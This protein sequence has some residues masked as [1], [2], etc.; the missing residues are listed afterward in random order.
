MKKRLKAIYTVEAS[1]TVPVF[2]VVILSVTM[3]FKMLSSLSYAES[4]SVFSAKSISDKLTLYLPYGICDAFYDASIKSDDGILPTQQQLDGF[5]NMLNVDYKL[6]KDKPETDDERY[7]S[8][9]SF[10]SYDELLY[11]DAYTEMKKLAD[12]FITENSDMDKN[13]CQEYFR[14]AYDKYLKEKS[15]L[16]KYNSLK[17]ECTK[18]TIEQ[19]D[20]ILVVN[21][22][23]RYDLKLPFGVVGKNSISSE[24]NITVPVYKR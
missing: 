18:A 16:S 8:N 9:F 14:Y 15:G 23:L 10:S 3:V 7:D 17:I 24:D 20:N 19:I 13:D 4:L 5:Y 11:A 21:F 6:S 1:L 2:I 22:T 12:E